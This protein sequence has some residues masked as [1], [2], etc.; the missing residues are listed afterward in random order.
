MKHLFFVVLLA[1]AVFFLWEFNVGTWRHL[2]TE[3]QDQAVNA[4]QILLLS[5][6]EDD[7]QN[8][9]MGG[10]QIEVVSLMTEANKINP[11]TKSNQV[12]N[13]TT[14]YE[15]N[16]V[17]NIETDFQNKGK[18]A[19]VKPENLQIESIKKIFETTDLLSE[20]A[21]IQ[22]PE[23]QKPIIVGEESSETAIAQTES[24]TT[25]TSVEE[26]TDPLQDSSTSSEKI[27]QAESETVFECY[28]IGPFVDVESRQ[29][30]L[31]NVAVKT[32]TVYLFS[33]DNPEISGY[34]VYYPAP[35]T[36]TESKAIF[37]M[38]QEQGITDIWLFRKGERRG[39]ISLGVY[40]KESRALR[41]KEAYANRDIMLKIQ[42][43]YQTKSQ[44]FVKLFWDKQ[45]LNVLNN[46]FDSVT[47]TIPKLGIKKAVSCDP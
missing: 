26:K 15:A 34:L 7:R 5:E 24:Y 20:Q 10:E 28:E 18:N 42:P 36:F 23:M 39:D 29:K 33:E 3:K 30:W 27:T 38:L 31:N 45:K 40:T 9:A 37:E 19:G 35:E 13:D 4:K 44:H 11:Q 12:V 14:Q 2:N 16:I 8:K 6:V 41:L 1:N 17:E 21:V 46:S 47:K 25:A 22:S 43:R 32:E